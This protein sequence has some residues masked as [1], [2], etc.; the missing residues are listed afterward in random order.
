MYPKHNPTSIYSVQGLLST[1]YGAL[2]RKTI[3]AKVA[4]LQNPN[5]IAHIIKPSALNLSIFPLSFRLIAIHSW[6][7][8]HG[9]SLQKIGYS[10]LSRNSSRW[11]HR[12]G[13][14]KRQHL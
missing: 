1:I 5:A 11:N 12:W 10:Q 9:P 2:P 6:L 3:I 4:K 14:R 8:N 7:R 13:D